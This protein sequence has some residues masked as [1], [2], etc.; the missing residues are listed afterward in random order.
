MIGSV[1]GTVLDCSPS[2]EVLIEVGGV[3]YRALVPLGALSGLEVGSIA[4]LFTHLNSRDDSLTLYG[5]PTR[6]ERDVFEILLGT[7]GVGPS[8]ALK[9]L[10]VHTPTALQR[11][12]TDQDLAALTMVPGVGKR[13]AERL[14]IEL[15]S[16]LDIPISENHDDSEPSNARAEVR[17]ALAGLGYGQDEVRTIIS[18]LPSGGSAEDLLRTALQMLATAR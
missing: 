12:V 14:V 17:A 9:I 13:T 6:T 5:F 15:R 3:G 2:G 11:A 18:R 16:R 1:R 7:I 8:L 4:F 10:S